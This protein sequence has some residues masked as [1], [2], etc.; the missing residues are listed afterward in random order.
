MTEQ[1]TIQAI[2]K[3]IVGELEAIIQYNQ[4]YTTQIIHLQKKYGLK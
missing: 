1:E 4:H 2:R 3:D